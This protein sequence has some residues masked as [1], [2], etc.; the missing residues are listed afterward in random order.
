MI[1]PRITITKY[2]LKGSQTTCWDPVPRRKL[3]LNN[4]IHIWWPKIEIDLMNKA[5]ESPMYVYN[6]E[7]DALVSKVFWSMEVEEDKA[8]HNSWNKWRH[9]EFQS[10][11][12]SFGHNYN[13][14]FF[15]HSL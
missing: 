4:A 15:S 7:M 6:R 11:E 1:D 12:V 5:Y 8:P 14:T 9:H 3:M 10:I 2:N 13:M